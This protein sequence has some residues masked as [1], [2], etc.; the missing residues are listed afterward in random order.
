[1]TG[2]VASICTVVGLEPSVTVADVVYSL[3]ILPFG[4][5]I[6]TL[7]GISPIAALSVWL[8]KTVYVASYSVEVSFFLTNPVVAIPFIV[9][10]A[11]SNGALNDDDGVD[12]PET[13]VTV[14]SSP[15]P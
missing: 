6:L 11:D 14:I 2:F 12:S 10:V 3:L 9:I 4:S 15:I 5:F 8:S 1:M 13:I 7:I